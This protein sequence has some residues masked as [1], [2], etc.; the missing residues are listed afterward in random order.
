MV[1]P[2][3]SVVLVGWLQL[4]RLVQLAGKLAAEV[5]VGV[6]GEDADAGAGAVLTDVDHLA[7]DEQ[8]LHSA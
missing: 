4:T 2:R 8:V 1:L 7:D 6:G 3:A 5:I